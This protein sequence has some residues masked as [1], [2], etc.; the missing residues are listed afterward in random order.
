MCL[1]FSSPCGSPQTLHLFQAQLLGQKSQSPR[2]PEKGFRTQ[3]LPKSGPGLECSH[4]KV[5]GW[6]GVEG[7]PAQAVYWKSIELFV[8]FLR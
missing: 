6:G 2:P 7:C 5:L 3:L 1:H 4:R 8:L